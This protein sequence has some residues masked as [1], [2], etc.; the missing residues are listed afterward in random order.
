MLKKFRILGDFNKMFIVRWLLSH[1]LLL[2][3]ALAILA[4][5]LNFGSGSNNGGDEHQAK[6]EAQVHA[7]GQAE[8]Q[9]TNKAEIEQVATSSESAQVSSTGSQAETV[10][11]GQ[12]PANQAEA[13]VADQASTQQ[14]DVEVATQV[15]EQVVAQQQAVTNVGTAQTSAAQNAVESVPTENVVDQNVVV[16]P[17][18]TPQAMPANNLLLMAR[19]AYWKGDF[20]TSVQYYNQLIKQESDNLAFK[21]ELA[22]V[23][24]K[25]GQA[26]EAAAVYADIAMPLIQAGKS[27]DVANMNEFIRK[28]FPEKAQAIDA[29]L[30]R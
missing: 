27:A 3:W 22:N 8:Q 12:A 29:A 28:Y 17:V 13:A 14:A 25:S 10:V 2:A 15:A 21:G 16:A 20:S 19:S 7:E 6:G 23:M 4:I 5:L 11:T 1:P 18:A 26:K 9:A 24:W 30:G